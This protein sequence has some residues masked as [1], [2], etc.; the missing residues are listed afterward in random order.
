MATQPKTAVPET[1]SLHDYINRYFGGVQAD[2]A[3][4]QGVSRQQVTQWLNKGFI[5]VDHVLHSKRRDLNPP[6]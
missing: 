4:A 5:V 1:L 6:E 3:D 2:F